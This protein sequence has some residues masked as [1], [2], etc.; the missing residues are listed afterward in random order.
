L[1]I[2]HSDDQT[3][4]EVLVRPDWKKWVDG[5]D[6]TFLSELM[7]EWMSIPPIEISRLFDELCRQS[8]GPLRMF[9]RRQMT[10]LDI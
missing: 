6:Q 1:L 10:V 2:L 3:S 7:D 5:A 4:L 9:R 8:R